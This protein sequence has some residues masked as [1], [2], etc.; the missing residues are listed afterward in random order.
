MILPHPSK[1]IIPKGKLQIIYI[2]GL[3]SSLADNDNPIKPFQDI[4]Q[5]KYGFNDKLIYKTI[6]EKIDV[7]KSR[8]FICFEIIP[9]NEPMDIKTVFHE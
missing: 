5:A 3:S 8:E 1:T 9:Y 2:F 6:I 4:L 7:E